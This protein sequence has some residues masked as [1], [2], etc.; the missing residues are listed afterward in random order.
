[1]CICVCVLIYSEGM[2]SSSMLTAD[3]T[4][5]AESE[6]SSWTRVRSQVMDML[7]TVMQLPDT[8]PIT[9]Q[10]PLLAA[11]CIT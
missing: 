10:V 1:M 3:I 7:Q 9:D 4:A 5:G 2:S 6:Q 11:H 8:A